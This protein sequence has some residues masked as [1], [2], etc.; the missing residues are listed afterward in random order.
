MQPTVALQGALSAHPGYNSHKEVILTYKK[1][2]FKKCLV[3]DTVA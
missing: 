2:E 1:E 3:V